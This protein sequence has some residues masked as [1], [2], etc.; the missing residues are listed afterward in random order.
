MLPNLVLGLCGIKY[1]KLLNLSSHNTASWPGLFL[2]FAEGSQS[3][4]FS[5]I[6]KNNGSAQHRSMV[7]TYHELRYKGRSHET[8]AGII[9][10]PY[11]YWLPTSGPWPNTCLG[12]W[13]DQNTS[14]RC[15]KLITLGS[16][17][18]CIM[19]ANH[20][21]VSSDHSS[22]SHRRNKRIIYGF[23][24]VEWIVA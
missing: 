5:S 18:T 14:R 11:L 10:Q 21:V 17:S 4:F 1:S 7:N 23:W 13:L 6:S 20:N 3:R 16:Y 8:A 15:L 12:S 24:N 19:L 9:I 22:W 2:F